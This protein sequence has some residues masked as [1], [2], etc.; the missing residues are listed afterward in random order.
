LI[1]NRQFILNM[2]EV[3]AANGDLQ[4]YTKLEAKLKALDEQER[5]SE[6]R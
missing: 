6:I 2:M 1:M 4:F 3:A 5:I